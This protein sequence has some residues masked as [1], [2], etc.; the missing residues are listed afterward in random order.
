VR[1]WFQ[2]LLSH[3]HVVPLHDGTVSAEYAEDAS[4]RLNTPPL[5]GVGTLHCGPRNQSDIPREWE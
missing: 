2:S 4:E 3:F 5:V 1:N